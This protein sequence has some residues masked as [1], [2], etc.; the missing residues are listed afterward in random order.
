MANENSIKQLREEQDLTLEQLAE[1][2]G[3]SVS[4]V[5]R[6]EKG[7]R[8]LSVK[9]IDR[10]AEAFSVPRTRLISETPGVQ[11]GV[12]G[13]VGAGG[14][15]DTASAQIQD[16][17]PLYWV[18]APFDVPDGAL[19]FHV[20][21]ESMWPKYDDGD[22]VICSMFSEH[23][24]GVIG[25]PAAVETSDG[26]RYLK[27]V[28]RGTKPGLYHL[29]SYNAPLMPDVQVVSFSSVIATIA[30]SQVA[31]ITEKVRRDVMRQIQGGKS[32]RA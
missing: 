20:R 6:L 17:E 29:E 5:Q 13:V 3:L 8:N 12:Y 18:Q 19:A 14:S 25:F 11:I 31:K 21:G 2:V 16:G 27:R 15:I 30:A 26:S 32:A 9:H 22:I 24:D 28:L 4:Y 7:D 23:A 10:F 1:R